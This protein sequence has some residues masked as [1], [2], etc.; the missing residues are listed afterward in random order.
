MFKTKSTPSACWGEKI[1]RKSIT[2]TTG[3]WR[4]PWNTVYLLLTL[5][6][7]NMGFV[8]IFWRLL[9]S[10]VSHHMLQ[11]Y[12]WQQNLLAGPFIQLTWCTTLKGSFVVSSLSLVIITLNHDCS[13]DI[14]QV[15]CK[16]H[17]ADSRLSIIWRDNIK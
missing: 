8:T 6:I 3:N 16:I 13:R 5:H 12:F 9:G 15:C 10:N 4:R 11:L 2:T 14:A 17:L 7:H 1:H